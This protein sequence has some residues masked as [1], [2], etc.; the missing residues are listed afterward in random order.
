MP[1]PQSS[2]LSAIH[3]RLR[4]TKRNYR[5][6]RIKLII[7]EVIGSLRS[8]QCVTDI[9]LIFQV[10]KYFNHCLIG[11]AIRVWGSRDESHRGNAVGR[12]KLRTI[13]SNWELKKY[14]LRFHFR[15]QTSSQY[16]NTKKVP[17]RFLRNRK[18]KK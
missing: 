17:K 6:F 11:Q 7:W 13:R 14:H 12:D 10:E 5:V 9:T 18:E 8:A 2:P 15:D 4:C 3:S 16:E 1:G